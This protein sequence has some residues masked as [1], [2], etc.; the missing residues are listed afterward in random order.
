MRNLAKLLRK[1]GGKLTGQYSIRLP[2]NNLDYDHIPVPITTDPT[3]LF[4]KAKKKIDKITDR[5]VKK[6]K[7]KHRITNSLFNLFMTPMYVAMK[8]FVI[9][10]LKD[11]SKEPKNIQV[12]YEQLIHL[13]DRS[14]SV[15]SNCTGCGICLKVCPVQNI[16]MIQN[17]PVWSNKCEM[18]FACDEWCPNQSIHHWGR[19]KGLKYHH[20][21]I[22]IIDIIN[23][24]WF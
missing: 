3:I 8:P 1:N 18:C 12:N 10:Q 5:I 20:P 23:L 19:S 7:E 21:D 22:K 13:T 17:R 14:I 6:K 9:K 15:D 24:Y 4:A 16:Q 2:M 11:Y